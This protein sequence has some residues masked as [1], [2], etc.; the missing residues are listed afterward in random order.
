[1]N[2]LWILT[3][4]D[5][6]LSYEV[7]TLAPQAFSIDSLK[8]CGVKASFKQASDGMT[9]LHYA[10]LSRSFQVVCFL[11]EECEVDVNSCDHN[12]Q[13]PLHIAYMSG[14]T[15]IAEYLIK[16]GADELAMD[17]KGDVPYC[18]ID[19]LLEF[20]EISKTMQRHRIMH[21]LPGGAEYVY[22]NSGVKYEEAI[23]LT[24]KQFPL[25]TEDGPTQPHRDVDCTLF[26]KELNQFIFK[27]QQAINH[28]GH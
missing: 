7:L 17:N 2:I 20:I 14:Q 9:L 12:L 26:R 15:C 8:M 25:L 18:Y 19:R 21:Q 6:L 24:L 3:F 4:N 11:V 16:H 13:T 28:G 27:N 1:M 5:M 22:C 23:A 10:V